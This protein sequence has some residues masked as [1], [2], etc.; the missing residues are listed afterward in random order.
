[1]E[2]LIE[3]SRRNRDISKELLNKLKEKQKT[4][5]VSSD[6]E[7]VKEYET[8]KI[9]KSRNSNKKSKKHGK[10]FATNNS[11]S[12]N[13]KNRNILVENTEK[14]Q[15]I[16][17]KSNIY[18][19]LK[20]YEEEEKTKEVLKNQEMTDLKNKMKT[21]SKLIKDYL[22]PKVDPKKSSELR[23]KIASLKHPVLE[24]KDV[25][26]SYVINNIFADALTRK[27]NKEYNSSSKNN[28]VEGFESNNLKETNV[29]N[30]VNKPFTKKIIKDPN[31]KERIRMKRLNKEKEIHKQLNFQ[32]QNEMNDPYLNIKKKYEKI[33][34]SSHKLEENA[35]ALS[36]LQKTLS[37]GIESVSLTEKIS[38]NIFNAV[39]A[40]LNILNSLTK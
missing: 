18:E 16:P 8:R 34:K 1:M 19:K 3:K 27:I 13:R 22:I 28:S 4:E 21:Y 40:K 6:N 23:F 5:I 25:K 32:I 29:F 24:K 17:I 31:D 30:L 33:S 12:S 35:E 11:K 37:N 15:Y 14:V 2:K 36:N 9:L 10:F 7:D 26:N 20:K 39:N 38:N